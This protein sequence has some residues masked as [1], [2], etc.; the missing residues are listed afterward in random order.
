MDFLGSSVLRNPK[1]EEKSNLWGEW[2]WVSEPVPPSKVRGN[3]LVK[4]ISMF[5]CPATFGGNALLILSVDPQ[6]SVTA[7][8]PLSLPLS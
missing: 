7:L 3:A 5:S 8:L 2:V 6:L 4:N 1:S